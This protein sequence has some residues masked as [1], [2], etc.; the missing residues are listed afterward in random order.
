M[1]K[2]ALLLLMVILSISLSNCK[3]TDSV[4]FDGT[5]EN[6]AIVSM[7]TEH[8]NLYEYT[9][10]FSDALD[11]IHVQYEY[12]NGHDD[13]YAVIYVSFEMQSSDDFLLN[14]LD[15]TYQIH[16]YL[17]SYIQSKNDHDDITVITGIFTSD[18]NNS[19]DFRDNLF[20]G[21]DELV[22]IIDNTS[23]DIE[24][25]KNIVFTYIDGIFS[26]KD[27]RHVRLKMYT[28]ESKML[29]ETSTTEDY[30]EFDV[31]SYLY[32]GDEE[33]EY[34]EKLRNEFAIA[35]NDNIIVVDILW[36]S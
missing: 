27:E 34:T 30:L 11:D 3:N 31:V 26:Y 9:D 19:I 5:C 35:L 17:I 16:R 6:E 14:H 4:C 24:V 22:V 32:E 1:K 28:S 36:F 8:I 2:I 15:E 25:F 23:K 18:Q 10:L 7:I 12:I 29:L 13:P 21:N 33:V 20:D